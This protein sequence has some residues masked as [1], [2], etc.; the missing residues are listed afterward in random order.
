[1][2]RILQIDDFLWVFRIFSLNFVALAIKIDTLKGIPFITAFQHI[3]D[4]II[5]NECY[6]ICSSCDEQLDKVLK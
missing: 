3:Y 2:L 4:V 1:M 6:P 5:M